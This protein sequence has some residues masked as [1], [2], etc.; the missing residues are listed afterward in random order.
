[1]NQDSTAV[2]IAR[3]LGDAADACNFAP[4][5]VTVYN[6]LRYAF[7]AH[8][9]Y[10]ERYCRPSASVLFVGMNPGPWGMVQT[11]VP[12][13]EVAA[14]RDWLGIGSG[15]ERPDS[16]HPKRPVDGFACRRSEVSGKR[17]WGWARDRFRTPDIFFRRFFV[18][19]YCPLAF[20]EASGRNRT[21]DKLKAAER[22]S[23]Y[24]VCDRA[25]A[26][27]AAYI[28]PEIVLGIGA[29]AEGRARSV[30][31]DQVRVH[32]VLHPSP[33]SPAA[34]RGWTEQFETRLRGLGVLP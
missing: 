29:Y 32:R 2:A 5:V 23:L 28:K 14:V 27:F 19:N 30:L 21:P 25:L 13:G 7:E 12:F 18:W 20:L 33:A 34:N 31:G 24:A 10:L 8:R 16:T 6:P 11:G 1:M 4:P 9:T 22:T 26:E 15:V 17:F 3:R